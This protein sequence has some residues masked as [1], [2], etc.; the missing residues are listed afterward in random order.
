MIARPVTEHVFRVSLT[1]VNVFLIVL[2]GGLTLVDAGT[3]RS[4]PRIAKAIGE[5]GRRPE[6]VTDI[7][8]THLHPDHT[9]GLAAARQ[10]TGARVWMHAADARMVRAGEVRRPLKAAPGSCHGRAVHFFAGTRA[11]VRP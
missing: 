3:R 7:V 2:P 4:W 1:M 6:E 5:L 9:G 10:A 11:K 8:V